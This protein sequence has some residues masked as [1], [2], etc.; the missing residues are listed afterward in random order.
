M[1]V[2]FNQ[3][4]QIHIEVTNFQ[5]EESVYTGKWGKDAK[6]FLFFNGPGFTDSGPFFK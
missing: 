3:E 6:K 4:K 2:K 5:P 1:V